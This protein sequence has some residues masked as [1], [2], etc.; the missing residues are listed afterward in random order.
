VL[1]TVSIVF[2]SVR[3]PDVDMHV[4]KLPLPKHGAPASGRASGRASGAAS[5]SESMPAS[6]S[7]ATQTGGLW[8]KSQVCPFGQIPDEHGTPVAIDGE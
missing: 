3:V 5:A 1:E 7:F 8:P 2:G 6:T 4:A